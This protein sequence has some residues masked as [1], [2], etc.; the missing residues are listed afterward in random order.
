M[1]GWLNIVKVSILPKFMLRYNT[2]PII[3]PEDYRQA[4]SEMCKEIQKIESS[5]NDF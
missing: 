2:I 3:I 1:V 4:N 5:W